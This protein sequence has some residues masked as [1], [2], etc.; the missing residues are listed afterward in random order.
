VL[1]YAVIPF[2][3]GMTPVDLNIGILFFAAVGSITTLGLLAAGWASDNKYSLLGGSRA[4]AQLISYEIPMGL[5]I[6]TVSLMAGSLS[7]NDIVMAQQQRG[8]FALVMPAVFLIYFLAASA[9]LGRSP[10]DLMEADSEIVAGHM[11]EYSGMKFAL[12]FLA[13][14]I[15][16]FAVSGIMVTLFLGGYLGPVLPSWIWFLIKVVAVI[17]VMMWIRNTLPRLRID[18]LLNFSWKVLVPAAL[19][20]LMLVALI[21]KLF[22]GASPWISGAAMLIANGILLL[23]VLILMGWSQRRREVAAQNAALR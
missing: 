7:T 19:V 23:G 21:D 9:E 3:R 16:F 18:Q 8:W 17:F 22:Q 10:F 1:T 15:N 6:I 14:Y 5:S 2:G 20:A 12:F 4:A 13:E 11:V